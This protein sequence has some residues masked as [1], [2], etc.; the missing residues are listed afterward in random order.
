MVD[1]AT[2]L[3][4][5]NSTRYK[6]LRPAQ[7]LALQGYAAHRTEADVAAELPT[8]YGKT[9][10]ALLIADISLEQGLTVAHLTGNNQLSDQVIEQSLGLPGLD[11]VKFSGGN[12]PPAGLA[13][14]HDARAVGVMNYWTYFNSSPK[15]EPADVVIFDDAH[16][17]EQPL[18]GLFAIRIDRRSQSDLYN[19]MCDLVL[20]HTDLYPSVEMMRE[21]SAGPTT[22]PELLAFT[23]WNAIADR[24]ADLLSTRLPKSDAQF[25]WP[26]VRPHLVAC[27]VLVGPSAIEIRPYHPP[28]QTLPGY[29]HA[30]QRLYLSAT[31]G[32]MDDL[33]RRLGVEP[34]TSVLDDPVTPGEVGQRLFLLN[35]GESGPLEELPFS[36]ALT[37]AAA[38]GRTAWLCASHAEADEVERLLALRSLRSFR[39]RGGGDDGALE[40]WMSD[41][42]GHLVT[43]GRYDGLDLA[44][45]TCRL[46]VM[47]SVPAAS[48]EFE[49]FVMA[50]LG[51]AS[52][53]RHRVGQRVTQAL[54]RANRQ[55]GDWAMYLGLAPGFGTLLAQSGVQAAIPRDVKP[56]V[57]E[58][59]ARLGNG[60]PPVRTAAAD[61]WN[62]KGSPSP[63]AEEPNPLRPRPGRTRAAATAGSATDEVTAVTRMWLGD[64]QRAS[65]AASQA[66]TKL[67]ASGEV[68]HAA[69]WRY[70]EAQACYSEGDTGSTGKAIDA[71]RA[72][73]DGGASTGWFVRLNRVL[74]ELRG[75]QAIRTDETPWSEWDE[76]LREAGAAG[77]RRAID[78]CGS[79]LSGSHDERAEALELIGRMAGVN[80]SRPS[81]QAVT[82]AIWNWPSNRKIERRLWEVKTGTPS[83]LPR[84]WV[85]QAL[86][87]LADHVSQRVHVVGCIVTDVAAVNP[88]AASAARDTLCLVEFDAMSALF[89]LLSA[90]LVDYCNRWGGGSAAERGQAREQV[91]SQLPSGPWLADLFS[92]SAGKLISR[93]SVVQRF[94]R[95]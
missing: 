36:F 14:Y 45:D 74:V 53:M 95:T 33:Q 4:G 5:F 89:E 6:E 78:R 57:D 43:A 3:A 17:A 1:F 58:S 37:Q 18:A 92:P 31:L 38:A 87:Q 15:V 13:A 40:Q 20:A 88:S 12:Y 68:E 30:R 69:F 75:E 71:L 79:G 28:T 44:G 76:W 81:G 35:P 16:L 25:V 55:E 8:G 65:Q 61:F 34:V 51:D 94:S 77:I 47:P 26:T 48:T 7:V 41:A 72:A 32:T 85:D 19:R 11:A 66:A 24:A 70:V 29:R 93:E 73:T 67:L 2:R 27:G 42:Q 21:D 54:G 56:T 82:D 52:F 83:E 22:P 90:R 50:Y 84:D 63:R 64:P 10:V 91:E 59:L 23:H 9:L 46:V 39:L 86:G 80:A 49:R 60:W 62:S